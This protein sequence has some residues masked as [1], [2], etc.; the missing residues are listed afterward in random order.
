MKTQQFTSDFAKQFKKSYGYKMGGSQ[1]IVFPNGQKFEFNDKEFYSGRGAKYNSSIKHDTIGDVFVSEAQIKEAI[2]AEKQ[3]AKAIRE[4]EREAKAKAK[5]I[6]IAKS[7]G[8]YDLNKKEHGTFV[9]LS[10]E[11]VYGR[12]F[13]AERLAATLKI[14][15][16]DAELLKSQGKTYVFARSEDG[17]TYELYHSSLYCNPLNIYVAK[18][19]PERIAEFKPAEW[20]SEP[21]A[22]NVGQSSNT[23][24]FVC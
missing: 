10:D 13:D 23:N 4:R 14:S 17:N 8:R 11:E 5:R 24:H 9:E 18:A 19:S 12:F 20:H 21:Y 2:K 16:S 6:A 22:R 3:R 7:E 15:I 1:T